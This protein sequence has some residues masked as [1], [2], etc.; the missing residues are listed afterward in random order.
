VAVYTFTKDSTPPMPGASLDREHRLREQEAEF[1]RALTTGEAWERFCEGLRS[2]GRSILR[3]EDADSDTD[4]AEGYQYLLGLVH[5]LVERELYR[6]DA[7]KPAFLRAQ[8]DVVKVGMDNPDAALMAAPISDDGVFRIFGVVGSIR[9][10]EFVI[11]GQGRPLMRNLDE[12]DV[13]PSGEFQVTLSRDRAPGNWIELPPGASSVL[14]R[15]AT[16]DWDTEEIPHLSIERV[17]ADEAILPWCLRIPTAA[18]IGEQLDAL[19]TLVATNAD[20]WIDMVH[21]F[22]SEG[23]NVIPAPRPLPSTGMN[24]SR[25]SVKGFFVLPADDALLVEFT[26]PEGLFWSISVGDMWYRTFDYSH[27]QTSLN[28]HQAE[29][30]ADGVCRV[31][32]AHQDPGLANWLDTLGH[33][34]G[35][36]ILRWV[37][38]SHRPQPQTRIVPFAELFAAL[39]PETRQVSDTERARTLRLRRDA[40][41]RRLAVPLTTRWSYSTSAMDPPQ[42][43]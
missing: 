15:R 17:G 11:S 19:G 30:D 43:R 27:H 41:A 37:M 8:S 18:E 36:V 14:V 26:P 38:V 32:L 10:L 25:S 21:S 23:D 5:S 16:Y 2:A 31:V 7:S 28:G 3:S 9:M 24:E 1:T 4:L 13:D 40:V 29:V 6:T 33:H 39:P 34:Q 12:F 35:V 42:P 22:R 20:Y